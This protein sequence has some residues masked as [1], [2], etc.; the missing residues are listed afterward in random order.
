MGMSRI[1]NG[2]AYGG[3]IDFLSFTA[4]WTVGVLFVLG[5]NLELWRLPHWLSQVTPSFSQETQKIS[6]G[7]T[8]DFLTGWLQPVALSWFVAAILLQFR[9]LRLQRKKFEKLKN[10]HKGK[11]SHSIT[12]KP[13]RISPPYNPKLKNIISNQYS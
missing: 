12:S 13:S 3:L 6:L 4:C 5:Y 9:E 7:E 2:F 8:G 10:E 11:K 1:G